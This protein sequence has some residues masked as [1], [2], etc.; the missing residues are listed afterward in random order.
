MSEHTKLSTFSSS[1]LV[2]FRHVWP[3]LVTSN[4]YEAV[5]PLDRIP[6]SPFSAVPSFTEMGTAEAGQRNGVVDCRCKLDYSLPRYKQELTYNHE[7][8]V[9]NK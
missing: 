4:E 8:H 5:S 6:S 7:K 1:K 9:A 3:V 2:T